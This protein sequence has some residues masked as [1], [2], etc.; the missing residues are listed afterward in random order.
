MN[1]IYAKI[2]RD[3]ITINQDTLLRVL[4]TMSKNAGGMG[5]EMKI[6]VLNNNKNK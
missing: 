1:L 6:T 2:S 3:T 4:C 5:V